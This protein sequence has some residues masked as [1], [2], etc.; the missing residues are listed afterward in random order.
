MVYAISL[1]N[2]AKI[3]IRIGGLKVEAPKG[4]ESW[5]RC[6]SLCRVVGLDSVSPEWGTYGGA[7]KPPLADLS[8][9]V[10]HLAIRRCL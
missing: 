7:I 2:I 8:Y 3:S 5:K 4:A 10:I 6:D 9:V 1:S